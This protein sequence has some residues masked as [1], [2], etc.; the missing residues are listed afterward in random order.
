MHNEDAGSSESV[1]LSLENF[2]EIRKQNDVFENVVD[3]I[4]SGGLVLASSSAV[5][6]RGGSMA[7]C[8]WFFF[9]SYRELTADFLFYKTELGGFPHSF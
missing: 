3:Y 2:E 4:T 6:S 9:R 5:G 7:A 1:D 8:W